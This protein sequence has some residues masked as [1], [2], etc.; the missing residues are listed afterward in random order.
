MTIRKIKETC[1]YFDNLSN[2]RSFYHEVLGF[3]IIA[4]VEGRHIFFRVGDDVLLCFNPKVTAKDQ[5]L[6]PHFAHGNQHIA[7]EVSKEDYEGWKQRILAQGIEIIHEHKWRNNAES[8]YF[9]DPEANV[10]EIVPEGMWDWTDAPT[11][12]PST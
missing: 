6:P 1:L 4:E 12:I 2:A 3:P 5:H 7:F 11:K 8:L 9:E 10:L